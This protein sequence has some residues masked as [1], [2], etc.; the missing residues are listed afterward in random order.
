MLLGLSRAAAGTDHAG[1]LSLKVERMNFER[2]C[3]CLTACLCLALAAC[4][5]S[6]LRNYGGISPNREVTKAFEEYQVNPEFRYYVS[7]ADLHPNALIG[8][9]RSHRLDPSTLWREVPMSTARMKTIVDGMKDKALELGMYQHGFDILDDRGRP[10]GVWYSIL[11]ARTFLRINDDGTV[12]INT[13]DLETYIKRE[14]D[15]DRDRRF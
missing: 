5:A 14:K 11:E 12:W 4:P 15:T 2:S 1:S 13:P 6:L 10:I 9:H 7:G 8:L 3:L